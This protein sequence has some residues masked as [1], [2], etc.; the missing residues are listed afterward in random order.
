MSIGRGPTVGDIPYAV[1]I[2]KRK[3]VC[4][5]LFPRVSNIAKLIILRRNRGLAV[6]FQELAA[7]MVKDL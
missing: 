3:L 1:F 6:S 4:P 7:Q 2:P 5:Q